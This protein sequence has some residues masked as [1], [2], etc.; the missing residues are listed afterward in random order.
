MKRNHGAAA[1]VPL[2][3]R[4][5]QVQNRSGQ[6]RSTASAKSESESWFKIVTNFWDEDDDDENVEVSEDVEAG[7]AEVYIYSEI[8]GWFGIYA[9]D[10]IEAI[11]K[12]DVETINLH[13]NSPGGSIFDGV[14]IY[15]SL[16]QHK[17]RIVVS[18]DSLAASAA[19]FIAQAG[20]EIIMRRA[21]TMMIHD[22]SMMTWGDAA[23]LRQDAE[24]LDKLSNNIASIYAFR[25][26]GTVEEWRATMIGEAWYTA[27]EAVEAGL[28]DR[29]DGDGERAENK[30]DLSAF[31][32][33]G[34]EHAPSPD[35]VRQNVMMNRVIPKEKV[36]PPTPQNTEAEPTPAVEPETPPVEPTTTDPEAP[37]AEPVPVAPE[38]PAD[39]AP[40]ARASFAFM[41]NGSANSDF[42]AVQAHINSLEGFYNES[43][44][45]A[46]N[47]FIDGLVSNGQIGAPQAEGLK[48]VVALDAMSDEA[49]ATFKA[50]YENAPKLPLLARHGLQASDGP[51][52]TADKARADRI[53]T[54]R[55]I[56]DRHRMAGKAEA[57]IAEMP[58]FKE[59]QELES[60]EAA[61]QGS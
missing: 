13:I 10:F 6:A 60:L 29:V 32:H 23:Q 53:A 36:M 20:D 16:I 15:N 58:S 24:I 1:T 35:L 5:R 54:L 46:R 48:Q 47:S 4:L 31:N 17:A 61:G 3:G 45:S 27:A 52:N 19:S 9:D 34:R 25:A 51:G 11:N 38:V 56:V 30:F 2:D 37:D 55:D 8:G 39:R 22:G 14:A 40:V 26:G 7:T 50:T 43:R 12:L 42:N 44:V 18:V 57:Q 21:S 49:F 33:A 28:A 59:L 41:V